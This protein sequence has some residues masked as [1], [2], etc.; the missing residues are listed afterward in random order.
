[1]GQTVGLRSTGRRHVL[2]K[3]L[4]I[5]GE[6]RRHFVRLVQVRHVASEQARR[7]LGSSFIR[8]YLRRLFPDTVDTRL[9]ASERTRS[10]AHSGGLTLV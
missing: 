10:A 5:F 9:A 7:H 3:A 6:K 4:R 1:M 8:K 2:T